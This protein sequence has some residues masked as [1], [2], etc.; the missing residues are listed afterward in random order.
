MVLEDS[1][2]AKLCKLQMSEK[3]ID[4]KLAKSQGAESGLRLVASKVKG[5]SVLHLQEL[6][7]ANNLNKLGIRLFLREK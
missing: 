5:T 3:T 6:N 4:K 1:I 7:S 2:A